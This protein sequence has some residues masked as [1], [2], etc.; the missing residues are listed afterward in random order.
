MSADFGVRARWG[1]WVASSVSVALMH[2]QCCCRASC[3]PGTMNLVNEQICQ[4]CSNVIGGRAKAHLWS[5]QRVVCTKCLHA[6]EATQQRVAVA[7]RFAGIAHTPWL[8][9]DG[10]KQWGPYPTEQLIAP[11]KSGHV[12]WLWNC[13]REGMENWKKM[14]NLFTMPLVAGDKIE[15]RNHGQ[16]DGRQ[17]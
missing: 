12:A 6:L 16:G 15:L 13:W 9:H 8:V 3:N 14:G 17:L 4:Q 10:T 2:G 5:D 7:I 11:L 1:V